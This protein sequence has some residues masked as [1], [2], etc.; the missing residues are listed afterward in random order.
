MTL[1]GNNLQSQITDDVVLSMFPQTYSSCSSRGFL[2]TRPRQ[3]QDLL[4]AE[5]PL[6]LRLVHPPA[7]LRHSRRLRLGRFGSCRQKEAGLLG[8]RAEGADS[9]NLGSPDNIANV[10]DANRVPT[11]HV[12]VGR[13]ISCLRDAFAFYE[14]KRYD[15]KG[16][17]YLSTQAKHYVC[18]SGMRYAVLGA[19]NMDW[20]RMYENAVFLELMRR[21]YETYV[22]KLYQKGSTSSRRGGRSSST[23]KFLSPRPTKHDVVVPGGT[24][25]E[26][27]P[28]TG[29]NWND[30][31][32][33]PALSSRNEGRICL[34]VFRLEQ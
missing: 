6:Q 19:R 12:T 11:N 24:R 9:G 16:K 7:R 32:A 4:C 31:T 25:L 17:R 33:E 22:G 3:W 20:G 10:L 18:D 5:G 34:A 26:T 28:K 29:C 1:F 21:G 14:A 23:S 27:A 15:I 2:V 13:C 30:G 8:G